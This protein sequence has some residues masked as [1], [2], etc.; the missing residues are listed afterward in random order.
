M[1]VTVCPVSFLISFDGGG[2]DFQTEV[3]L[4]AGQENKMPK[5]THDRTAELHNLAAHTPT[6]QPRPHTAREII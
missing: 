4:T 3:L 6:P 2:I 1:R 5:S